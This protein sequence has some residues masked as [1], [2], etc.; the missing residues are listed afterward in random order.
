VKAGAGRGGSEI[1]TA[2][3]SMLLMDRGGSAGGKGAWVSGKTAVAVE[4]AGNIGA[5]SGVGAGPGF[6]PKLE[7]PFTGDS[8]TAVATTPAGASDT[9]GAPIGDHPIAGGA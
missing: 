4:L 1:A 7:L 9:T 6:Q 2:L 3:G 5:G 8:A